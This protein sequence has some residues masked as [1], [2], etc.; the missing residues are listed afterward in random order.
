MG[1]DRKGEEESAKG[2]ERQEETEREIEIGKS[3]GVRDERGKRDLVKVRHTCKQLNN[4][5]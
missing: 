3:A 4:A 2:R 1:T 5:N